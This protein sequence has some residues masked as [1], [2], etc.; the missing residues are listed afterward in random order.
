MV[1]I[2]G[3]DAEGLLAAYAKVHAPKE[4]PKTEE[5]KAEDPKAEDPKKGDK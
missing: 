3:K 2:T 4:E 1:R 5:P